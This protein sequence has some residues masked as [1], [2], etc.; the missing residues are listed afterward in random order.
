MS[1]KLILL[2]N[3][4]QNFLLFF[5]KLA[6]PPA[7]SQINIDDSLGLEYDELV[8]FPGGR[9]PDRGGYHGRGLPGPDPLRIPDQVGLHG[10]R[11]WVLLPLPAVRGDIFQTKYK[12]K[13]L[14]SNCVWF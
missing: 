5:Y 6:Q 10:L 9:C 8:L 11:R 7:E 4:K 1:L 12:P 3:C 2:R 14:D 13:Q